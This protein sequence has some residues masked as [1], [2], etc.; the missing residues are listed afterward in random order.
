M[1]LLCKLILE[2]SDVEYTRNDDLPKLYKKVAVLLALNAEA[3][4][5]NV[6]A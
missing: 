6:K 4:D 2:H 3:V 1:E 5:D